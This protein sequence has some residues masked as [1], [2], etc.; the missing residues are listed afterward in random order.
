[1]GKNN[2][3]R[4]NTAAHTA[5][6]EPAVKAADVNAEEASNV[7]EESA[8]AV[9]AEKSVEQNSKN[10]MKKTKEKTKPNAA[11]AKQSKKSAKPL[12][13]IN[14]KDSISSTKLFLILAF[15]VPFIVMGVVFAKA[16]VYPFGDRQVMYSDCKQQY[17]PYLKEYQRKLQSGDSM[18]Y[19]WGNGF[20]T[21]FIAMIAYYIASPLN[22]LTLFVPIEYIRE[23][24]AVFM[25]IKI[26]CASLFMAIFLKNVFKRNDLS[27]VAFGCCYAF[28]DFFMGYYWNIIWL[29]SVAL[30]PL[31]ALGVY[32]VVNEKKYRLYIISLAV[33]F[34]ASY[35][36]GFMICVFVVLWFLLLHIFRK[37]KFEDF[38]ES[39]LRMAL[40]SVI[41][42]AMTLPVT[43]TAYIELTHTV[44]TSDKFP[45]EIEFYNNFMEILANLTS[46]HPTTTMEGLPN[47]GC[48][49]VCVLLIAVF[50]RAKE[51]SVRE[52]VAYF[53]LLGF[54]FV[55]LNINT[56]DYIW[57]GLH[58]PNQIPYRFAFLFS[59][60]LITMAYRGFTVFV[61]LDKRDI[62]SMIFVA[63][64]LVC[65][66]V[67]Y[68]DDLGEKAIIGSLIVAA[69]YIL[70]MTLHERELIDRRLLTVF[71]SILIIVEMCIEANIG[72]ATVGT[73]KHDGYPDDEV[74]VQELLDYAKSQDSTD[75]YRIDQN[76]FSTKNDGMIYGYNGIGQ[77]SSTSYK[78][79]I[80]FTGKF[81]M[82]SKRSSYQYML[83]SPV[84]S[85]FLNV[86]YL[87]ARESEGN[88]TG[89]ETSLVEVAEAES[90]GS[91]LYENRYYLPIGYM[92]E[93]AINDVDMDN[94][95]VFTTQN[96][97]FSA[98]TGVNKDVYTFLDPTGFY[99]KDMEYKKDSAGTYSYSFVDGA[100]S[101][102]I[103]V[104]YTAQQDGMIYAW[105]NVKSSKQ[106]KVVSATINHTYEIESH[107]YIFPLGYYK[108][109]ETVKISVDSTK[110]GKNIIGVA[111]LNADVLDEG[112]AK[113]NDEALKVTNYSS[114][115][116]EGTIKVNSDGTFTTS[117]PYEKGW[118]LYVDGVRTET[119][120]VMGAFIAA[121][122]T[123]GEHSIKLTYVPEG[124]VVGT[125]LAVLALGGFVA[126]CVLDFLK[127]KQNV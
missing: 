27:L 94:N 107:R 52:K 59:F 85:M 121:D 110:S 18:F 81:G 47:I 103:E 63:V 42:L 75:F 9:L 48:G 3:K 55:S 89:G 41:G 106:V 40:Y 35:Y 62:V 101:G 100:T 111:Q 21:N 74:G 105:A 49:V 96:K 98:A 72:V 37:S 39:I 95:S 1:M 97:I 14:N 19:S 120:P 76:Y 61:K 78:T 79:L 82:V 53:V 124:F 109:G 117:V 65:I 36:I 123:E 73:T 90:S 68:A 60:V 69:V 15:F 51:I 28:C 34:L 122:L 64:A 32:Y 112:Y 104:E 102:T 119:K 50:A 99:C 115:S 2:K 88:Y 16:G 70:F 57:H 7:T 67:F 77:F 31:V 45:E 58:F 83:T 118:K 23:A 5:K 87:I 125:V 26:S 127:K 4:K 84:T 30:L 114:T 91:K 38:C 43:L 126:L 8:S 10:K 29:D 6:A 17:L 108:K 93:Y 56:L 20:G 33:G 66:S 86:K 11:S 12:N 44:G 46:F 71:A 116:I 25:M 22:L 24:M 13:A 92:S 80:D 54:L 113:L